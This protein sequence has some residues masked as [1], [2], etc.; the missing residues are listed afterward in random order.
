M[1]VTK[2]LDWACVWVRRSHNAQFNITSG[3]V[4]CDKIVLDFDQR[5][6]HISRIHVTY[7]IINTLNP[8]C[9]ELQN[10]FNIIRYFT[11][12]QFNFSQ[13]RQVPCCAFNPRQT[14]EDVR[15][16]IKSHTDSHKDRKPVH[17][18]SS[19]SLL[20]SEPGTRAFSHG[21]Q[22]YGCGNT[23][24]LWEG[25]GRFGAGCN[26]PAPPHTQP[27]WQYAALWLPAE[28]GSL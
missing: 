19:N 17:T 21:R 1:C 9:L 3:E 24:S 2:I 5:I 16:I 14:S 10:E 18:L 7:Y 26:N 15:T 22:T 28:S 12:H 6:I 8:V 13:E 20:T 25:R 23:K 11:A 27:L 4:S